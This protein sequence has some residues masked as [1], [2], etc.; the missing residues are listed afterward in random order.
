MLDI[1]IRAATGQAIC[2]PIKR[3]APSAVPGNL[4]PGK[5]T[6]PSGLL[7][8]PHALRVASARYSL[9][10]GEADAVSLF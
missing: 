5:A 8:L 4:R 7:S 6:H 1:Q 9:R 10:V 3:S 2:I